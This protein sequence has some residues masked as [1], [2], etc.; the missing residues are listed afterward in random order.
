MDNAE[1]E[2][3]LSEYKETLE[4]LSS[5]SKEIAEKLCILLEEHDG[6]ADDVRWACRT[7]TNSVD[8]V[9]SDA[10][11]R[12]GRFR[13]GD[14]PELPSVLM[15]A[16]QCCERLHDTAEMCRN[17]RENE[18]RDLKGQIESNI[19]YLAHHLAAMDEDGYL[20]EDTPAFESFHAMSKKVLAGEGVLEE[21]TAFICSEMDPLHEYLIKLR[22]NNFW[23]Q[24]EE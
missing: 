5:E 15:L 19:G 3:T 22:E 6:D 1:F 21:L 20:P 14:K 13:A 2:K 8:D 4:R 16:L 12:L 7:M 10:S 24:E 9:L 23:E 17:G 18:R 11:K